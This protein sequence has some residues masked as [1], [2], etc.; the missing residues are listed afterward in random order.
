MAPS[1]SLAWRPNVQSGFL[2]TLLG[3]PEQA[4]LRGGYSQSYERQGLAVFTGLYGGN[5]GSTLT[6]NRTQG[7]GSLVNT[8]AGET[9]P[10]LYQQK[11]RL[12]TGFYPADGG[13]PDRHPG[14]PGKQPERVRSRH[15]YRQRAVLDGRVTARDHPRHGRGH[16][17]RRHARCRSVVRR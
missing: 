11:D 6:V 3:D 15:P 4:T 2:R 1:I 17:L 12:Y 7:N 13:V 5:P 10:L 9:H 16:P 14:Q 8:A